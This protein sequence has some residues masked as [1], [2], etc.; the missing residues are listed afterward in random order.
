[1]SVKSAA[2]LFWS[3][4]CHIQGFVLFLMLEGNSSCFVQVIMRYV[5]HAR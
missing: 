3:F 2:R 1:M 4:L 5:L